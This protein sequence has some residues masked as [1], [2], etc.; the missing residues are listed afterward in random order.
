VGLRFHAGQLGFRPR[1]GEWC[2][3]FTVNDYVFGAIIV[4][5]GGIVQ[6]CAGFGLSLSTVPVMVFVFQPTI[7]TPVQLLLSLVN[8]VTVL[9]EVWRKAIWQQVLW[10]VAGGI[11]GIPLGIF[12]LKSL[13]SSYIKLG[14]GV[15]VLAVA[16]AMLAGWKL[17]LPARLAMLLP[18][19]LLSGILGG[20]TSL[21][22]PPVIL[23]FTSQH[24]DKDVFRAN[25]AAYFTAVNIAGLAMFLSA[26]LL[27]RTVLTMAAVFV[28]PLI[29]G[30]LC[31]ILLARQISERHFRPGILIV[32]ALIGVMLIAMNVPELLG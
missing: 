25:M 11:C 22:G 30:T 28:I 12:L 31:G 23:Y 20:S 19:G 16:S 10:L 1:L 29:A 15:I 14:I 3:L 9:T 2:S 13:A 17:R 18:V 26:G 4:F 24:P 8:N 6:G 32:L 27:T 7:L 5:F 21:N